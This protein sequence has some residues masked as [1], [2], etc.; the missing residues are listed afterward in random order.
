[1]IKA[2]NS[3]SLKTRVLVLV[4]ALIVAGLLGLA[5]RVTAVLQA[6]LEKASAEQLSATVGYVAADLDHEIQIRIEMLKHI[7][8]AIP[9][10][11]LADRASLQGVLE[12]RKLAG[13]LFPFGVFV[14][15]RRGMEIADFPLR[16]GRL[17]GFVGDRD[18]FREIMAGAEQAIGNPQQ[19]RFMK[20]PIFVIAVPLRDASGATVGMLGGGLLL[21]DPN[22]FGRLQQTRIGKTGFLLVESPKTRVIVAATDPAR[23]LTP[24]PRKGVNLLMDRRLETGFEGAGIT[25][26][27]RGVEV[28]SVARRMATTGWITI[29]AMQTDEAFAPIATLKRQIYVA[30]LLLALIMVV[31]LRLVL[32][33][34]LAPL[35]EAGTTMRR[36][37]EGDMPLAQIAVTRDDEIGRMIGNFNRLVHGRL[38]L[39]RKM[40]AMY[41]E[42]EDLYNHAP[43]GYHSID[44]DGVFVRMNDTELSWLG[45]TRDEV[46]GKMRVPNVL[47]P[48]GAATFRR[49]FRIVKETGRISEVEYD[50]VRKDGSVLPVILNAVAITDEQGNYLASRCVI[51]DRTLRK[52]IDEERSRQTE[53]LERRVAERTLQLREMTRRYMTVQESEKRRL[54]R[55]LHDRVSSNLTAINLN[56]GLI[57]TQ[58]PDEVGARVGGRLSDIAALVKDTMLSARDISADLHPA[59]LDYGGLLPA[60]E[61][62]GRSFMRRTGITVDIFGSE[63]PIR[64]SPEKEIALYRI[65]VEA[66]TNSAKHAQA[67]HVT[68]ELS[69][70]GERSTLTISDDGVGFDPAAL[71]SGDSEPGLGLLSMQERAEAIGGCFRLEAVRGDGTTIIVEL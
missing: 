51:H 43:C 30:T 60:L 22:L 69:S 58:L 28:L 26:N 10:G 52:Q 66:L 42:L 4:S 21:T 59:V 44:K 32:K 61:D 16:P 7:A 49:N 71:A 15:D 70:D 40:R 35:D 17:G 57:G 23:I 65:A 46:I 63:D 64:F 24:L 6:D 45:Y 5:L 36:M 18:Y 20:Q 50:W 54:A 11:M 3:M 68:I 53:Q 47:T 13:V 62:Y 9:P 14:V 48:E 67:H 27:E 31:I 34:Q 2:L 41:E 56:L 25:R 33:Q 55:E 37:T 12:Q 38:V 29:A 19:G 39:D 8:A 1:M